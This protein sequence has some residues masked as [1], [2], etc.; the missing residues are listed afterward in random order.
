MKLATKLTTISLLLACIFAFSNA[1]AGSDGSITEATITVEWPIC[2]NDGRVKRWAQKIGYTTEDCATISTAKRPICKDNGEAKRW[3]RKA[4]YTAEDCATTPPLP[5]NNS[6]SL[7]IMSPA[8][9]VQIEAGT[10]ITFTA[11]ASDTEDGNLSQSISWS[12]SIDGAIGNTKIVSGNVQTLTATLSEGSH[13]ITARVTDSGS[14]TT[15]DQTNVIVISEPSTTPTSATLSWSAPDTRE[16]GDQL[17]L[18]EIGGYQVHI[19]AESTGTTEIITLNDS[20][21]TS[22]T[23]DALEP[24]TYHVAMNC[25]DT[26]G[27][28]SALTNNTSLTI[29]P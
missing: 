14:L 15:T 18:S 1:S 23:F 13:T 9:S 26:D 3:A 19:T 28:F 27:L 16:N 7:T 25:F 5:T 11:T 20:T 8:S 24:D 10:P 6:P 2:R 4:G 29:D 12:S 17:I 22:L 21:K